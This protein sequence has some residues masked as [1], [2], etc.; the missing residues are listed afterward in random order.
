MNNNEVT[1]KFYLQLL[2]EATVSA[3]ALLKFVSCALQHFNDTS[4]I[5]R[6]LC[7]HSTTNCDIDNL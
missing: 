7:P 3:Q 4:A 1:F 6:G 2:N 5:E